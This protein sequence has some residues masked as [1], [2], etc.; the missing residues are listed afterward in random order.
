VLLPGGGTPDFIFD[1]KAD[2]AVV[3]GT[4][5]GAPITLREGRLD[6]DTLTLRGINPDNQQ[7]TFTGQFTSHEIVFRASGLFPEAY[8]FVARRDPRV[9]SNGSITDP[10]FMQQALQ[11]FN[12][13]GVSIAIVQDFRVL[14]AVAYRVADA[15]IGA[16]VTPRTMSRPGHRCRAS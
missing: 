8:H 5:S 3:T 14:L 9:Q 11:Q 1:L 4:R 2:G 15:E 13:P 10:A 12:V 7:V 6:G 16:P